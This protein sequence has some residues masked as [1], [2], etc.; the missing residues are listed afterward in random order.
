MRLKVSWHICRSC[1]AGGDF[2][3]LFYTAL[4]RFVNESHQRPWYM[5]GYSFS[6]LSHGQ[7]QT[8]QMN[9]NSPECKPIDRHRPVLRN[10][11][12]GRRPEPDFCEQFARR[13]R[14]FIAQHQ[15]TLACFHSD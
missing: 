7:H 13:R 8:C 15:L 2:Y 11:L 6:I 10:A 9:R 3:L 14:K 12:V 4:F 1:G 5:F